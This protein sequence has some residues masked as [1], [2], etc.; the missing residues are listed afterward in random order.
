MG[1]VDGCGLC[2]Q[3]PIRLALHTIIHRRFAAF[4]LQWPAC[5]GDVRA[6]G[7]YPDVVEYLPDI[8][9]VRDERNQAH[10]APL[11]EHSSGKTAYM[12]A[13]STDHR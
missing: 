5:R 4:P 11:F 8:S 13:I 9:V 7:L 1:A 2:H 12:R 6:F 3:I 10:L